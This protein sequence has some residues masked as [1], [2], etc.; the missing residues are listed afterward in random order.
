[1]RTLYKYYKCLP[2]DYLLNP[3]LKL[4]CPEHLNDPFE[5][6]I[7]KFISEIPEQVDTRLEYLKAV[8]NHVGL[9]RALSNT[10]VISMCET[11]RNLL[12]WAHYANEHNGFVIGYK[13]DILKDKF[14]ERITHIHNISKEPLKVN[15]DTIRFD[16][17]SERE[18]I[19]SHKKAIRKIL[20]TKGDDWIYEKEHRY[21]IPIYLA[22]SIF[23]KRS[24]RNEEDEEIINNLISKSLLVKDDLSKKVYFKDRFTEA[25][26]LIG[27]LEEEV[28]QLI[29][30]NHTFYINID[31]SYITSVYFGCRYPKTSRLKWLTLIRE[32]NERLS[33]IKLY[34]YEISKSDFSL[35]Y[36]DYSG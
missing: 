22:D 30:T 35:I 21:L 29:K 34:Q 8:V 24:E 25:P 10:G 16:S 1:M 14:N 32:Q 26:Y 33:H 17:K 36:E 11:H 9:S 19:N 13:D 4:A 7:S 28:S 20:T 12:M 27:R 5:S 6:S 2:D 3:T 31:P 18:Y 15:Y 23:K